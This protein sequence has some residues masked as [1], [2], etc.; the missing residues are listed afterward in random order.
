MVICDFWISIF[1]NKEYS[2]PEGR[3]KLNHPEF[4]YLF[5]D[6]FSGAQTT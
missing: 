2:W 5:N 1:K 4:I 6:A 3:R